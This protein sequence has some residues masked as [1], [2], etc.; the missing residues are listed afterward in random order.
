MMLFTGHWDFIIKHEQGRAVR[1]VVVETHRKKRN[2]GE[3][4]QQ[5]GFASRGVVAEVVRYLPLGLGEGSALARKWNG[6]NKQAQ[7][8]K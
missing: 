7:R 3:N 5:S 1:P 4:G 8:D 6:A 2:K